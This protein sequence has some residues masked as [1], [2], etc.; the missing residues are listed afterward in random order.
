MQLSVHADSL[1][2]EREQYQAWIATTEAAQISA[3]IA[4][5][6]QHCQ[7]RTPS[8][9]ILLPTY[10]SDAVFLRTALDSVLAQLY[11]HWQLCVIDDAS[12]EP[13]VR[14]LLQQ[15]AQRDARIQL[16]F[17]TNNRGIAATSNHAL[18]MASGE[19]VA[20]L[21]HDDVLS[22]HALLSVAASINQNSQ[23]Q[24]LY[25]DS[26]SL[27]AQGQRIEP[28]FKPGWNYD[29]LLG[30]NYVN[31]LTVYRRQRLIE[32]G[33]W[34]EG[35]EG[36]QDYDL[37][38]RVIEGL[39]DTQI[40]H[41]PE[42][43]Y[44][45]RQ[46][47]TSVSRANLGAAVRAART[48]IREHLQRTRQTANVKPCSGALLYNRIEW[49]AQVASVAIAVYGSEQDTIDQTLRQL[50]QFDATLNVSGVLLDKSAE[51]FQ[52]LNHWAT[53]Q[54]VA[55][56]GFI[57]AGFVLQSADTVSSLLG[58][59]SRPAVAAVS[60]KLVSSSGKPQGPL[61]LSAGADGQAMIAAAYGAAH[62]Q[63]NTGYVASLLLDRQVFALQ[64][65][66]LF[67]KAPLFRQAGGWAQ[68]PSNSLLAGID[69]S[70]R[71]RAHN[72]Y[73]VWNAQA[74]AFSGSDAL[75]A[76][77]GCSDVDI[78]SLQAED[79]ATYWLDKNANKNLAP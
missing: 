72:K 69:L 11:P 33:G 31:H 62:Q 64:A 78:R 25:S 47:P 53:Q 45:W 1:M 34:R 56:L 57:A 22:P 52:A 60:A 79:A 65:G 42:I 26:D 3:R 38:L 7:L 14:P 2:V 40:Y 51:N 37:L 23:A 61:V 50:Q 35:F 67:V 49:Q 70:L 36:S 21:D 27:D 76:E 74:P 10:N 4:E 77:I 58:Q 68:P 71:L 8:I 5:A 59:I 28:F 46:V 18:E 17:Q 29:L 30:Q 24:L 73:L 13:Q 12:G 9:S 43:L 6:W 16:H 15:Y 75:D 44:H 55:L 48:A 54:P 32:A 63:G 39:P 41:I 20:L 19:Y 66:C